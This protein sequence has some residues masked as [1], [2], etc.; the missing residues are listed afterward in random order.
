M[1]RAWAAARALALACCSSSESVRRILGC[2][3][4]CCSVFGAAAGRRCAGCWRRLVCTVAAVGASSGSC[5][6]MVRF[7]FFSTTTDFDRPWLNFCCTWPDSTVRFRLSGL[8]APVSTVFSVVSFVSLIPCL[9]Q[10][11]LGR[12][13]PGRRS[14]A[15]SR[16]ARPVS[17]HSANL[18]QEIRR[19][20][21]CAQCS[22]YH[23]RP[24]QGQT[25]LLDGQFPNDG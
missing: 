11:A 20:A 24:P 15:R 23:I 8:R 2:A 7:L 10:N 3:W 17:G 9:F 13:L 4:G 12:L 5:P 1:S 21:A 14:A 19:G 22:M 6:A 16:H 25:H 18:V